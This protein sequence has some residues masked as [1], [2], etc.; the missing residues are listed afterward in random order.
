MLGRYRDTVRAW[1]DPFGRVLFRVHLRPNHLTVAGLAA[2]LV[3]AGC[4]IAGQ[5]RTAGLVLIL[6]G[7]LDLLDGSL[8]RAS[9]QVTA[10]GAFLDSV[11]DR[12]SDI[13]V[14]LGI[15]VLYARTPN[16]R[17]AVV[18]MAGLAGS[19]MVSYTKARAESIGVECNVGMMERPE[20]LICLIAGALLDVMEPALWVLAVLANL[21]AVQRIVFTRRMMRAEPRRARVLL[22]LLVGALLL[23]TDVSA[24]AET[25]RAWARA[26]AA[27]QDGQTAPLA[28]A[29]AGE[30]ALAS[31]IGDYVRFIL[32]DAL[33]RDGDVAGAR[34]A[35]LS[36]ADQ[37]P[38][39][40]LAPRA[41]VL[42]SVLASGA[43][44][45]AGAQAALR[46][47]LERYP[48]VLEVPEAL[49]LLGQTAEARGHRDVAAL[50]YR[51]LRVLAPTTGY[52][53]AAADRLDVL[54][55]AG[56]PLPPL[57]L[58]ERIDRAERLLRGGVPKMAGDEAERIADE[59][60]DAGIVVR[61]LRVVGDA[62]ARLGRYEAGA[63]A[64][65]AAARRAPSDQQ[66]RLRIDQA[67]FLIRAGHDKRAIALL[68]SVAASAPE[69]ETA[70]AL[71]LQ[72][73]V[74]DEG[75]RDADAIALY[76]QIAGRFPNREV[77]GV[78]LWRL[79]WLAWL[80]GEPRVAAAEWRHVAEVS[81]GR[82]LR[83]PALYWR[84]RALE[85]VKDETGAE[86][87][88][89]RVL[90]E[91]PRGYYG[92]LAAP[93]VGGAAPA[94]MPRDIGAPALP[95]NPAE[96]FKADPRFAR[97]DLLRRIGL[98]EYAWEEL[99]DVV[100]S[101]VGD[102]IGLY[103]ASSA[104]VRD[105]RYHLA[106]RIVRRHFGALSTSGDPALP[107][108]FWEVI[109]PFG[110]RDEVGEAAKRAGLD[111][112]LVAAIVRE[113]SS[114]YPR[115]VSRAG[116]RGLMQL[117]PSTAKPMADVRGL[118]FEDGGVLD[119][120]RANLDIGTAFLAGLIKEFGDARLAIAAYN[121]GPKRVRDWWKARRTGDMEAFVE[122]IPYD[123]TRQYVKR[124]MLSWTEYRRLY[125][126]V[127]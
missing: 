84:A 110:W 41:L 91:A 35:A 5:T 51:Q 98:V 45:E 38:D 102:P 34:A 47:L 53:E 82:S 100:Q 2:S 22:P 61:A 67:R 27:F 125:G 39:S 42:V 117:M 55:G 124:V 107:R 19:V 21:T 112:F 120:P 105:E 89:A 81:G 56:T 97:V 95:A 43:G 13:A 103:G 3:A 12:Y 50:A 40:R 69:S 24:S 109:Y 86:A 25:E 72:A 76:R 79:G 75:S 121:A 123:E 96:A 104:Y 33:A 17:G 70:E 10:F 83:L 9:G 119:D 48:D 54:V 30:A 11:I 26:V 29:F 126:E 49:Y 16:P 114:Y 106:L 116:A 32:A 59:A 66:P 122:Q 113:E 14:M 88:Y 108:A 57:S 92:M 60:R 8:A 20:R 23:P 85:A 52:A 65:E 74:Y 36:V 46:R 99:E 6:A 78:A 87:L 44:D 68:A 94:A 101:S 73:R 58:A 93:R 71:A 90:A 115:A 111:P 7:L 31:P 1:S 77:A 80:R 118:A 127:K 28:Q 18:A 63:K 62:A 15:V 37:H 4:F 64:L